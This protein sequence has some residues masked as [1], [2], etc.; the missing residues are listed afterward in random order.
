MHSTSDTLAALVAFPTVSRDSNETLIGYIAGRLRAA[1]GAVRV[2]P[3]AKPGKSN[4]FAS[5]GPDNPGGIIL[6][7]H[8]DVVPVDGQN[9]TSDPFTLTGRDNRLI[10]RGAAD[11]K[12]FIACAMTAVERIDVKAMAQPLHIAI[13]CDEEIGCVGVRDM[14]SRLADEQFQAAGC[15]I[16]EPTSMMVATGHKGKIA[17]CICC[18]GEAAH[19]ADPL[20]GCNAINLAAGMIREMEELQFWLREHGARDAAYALPYSSVHVGTIK[21]GTVLNIVPDHCEMAFE[22][23]FLPGDTPEELLARLRMAGDRLAAREVAKGRRAAIEITV[24][25]DYPGLETPADAPI[26]ALAMHAAATGATK[27][28]FGTEAGLFGRSLGLPAVVCGPGSIDVAHK[29]DEYIDREQLAACD[30]FLDR[31]ADLLR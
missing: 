5:F 18:T 2:L 27:I 24:Q 3:G 13:S 4:L 20:L 1:G 7:G 10:A 29:P 17:G 9:W 21:G 8:S 12:G 23:R 30:V 28:S 25:N 14:L 16:G 15:I 26:A 6:S 11:M 22:I 19:S 31:V